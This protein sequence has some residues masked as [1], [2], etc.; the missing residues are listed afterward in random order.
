MKIPLDWKSCSSPERGEFSKVSGHLIEPPFSCT[1]FH[2]GSLHQGFGMLEEEN[3]HRGS[4]FARWSVELLHFLPVIIW[5]QGSLAP[6]LNTRYNPT[7]FQLLN[8]ASQ[9]SVSMIKY[10]S[11]SYF[12][13]ARKECLS[14]QPIERK[15]FWIC[16]WFRAHSFWRWIFSQAGKTWQM[17]SLGAQG[18]MAV[19]VYMP[20]DR[21]HRAGGSRGLYNFHF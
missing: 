1:T 15:I 6:N 4:L 10:L 11:S 21:E 7:H 8:S 14:G 18:C 16:V 19:I 3:P 9:A 20:A 2:I 12:C 5:M 17:P 13:V